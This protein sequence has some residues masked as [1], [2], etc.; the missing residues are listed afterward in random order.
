MSF[1]KSFYLL[2]VVDFKHGGVGGGFK[3]ERYEDCPLGMRV[4][5][6]TGVALGEGGHEEGGAL[7]GFEVGG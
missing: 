1:S 3:E 7:G 4:D 2:D 5:T 6:T